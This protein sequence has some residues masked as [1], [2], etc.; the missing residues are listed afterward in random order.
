MLTWLGLGNSQD[1]ESLPLWRG[2]DE[3]TK[4]G[5]LLIC[6]GIAFMA[7]LVTQWLLAGT[8]NAPTYLPL[9][10]SAGT[11]LT[12]TLIAERSLTRAAPEATSNEQDC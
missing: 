10:I 4:W 3:K 8:P 12:S 6:M 9:L 11:L 2:V 7:F 5:S 1:K